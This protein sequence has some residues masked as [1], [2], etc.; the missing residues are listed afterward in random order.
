MLGGR[1][2][3]RG[4]GGGEIIDERPIIACRRYA[5]AIRR[6]SQVDAARRFVK[7]G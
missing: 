6:R 4:E 3:G 2:R 7:A 1:G 5:I